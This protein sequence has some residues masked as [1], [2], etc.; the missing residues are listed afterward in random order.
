MP[1]SDINASLVRL[2]LTRLCCN[3]FLH[4]TNCTLQITATCYMVSGLPRA[5]STAMIVVLL[6]YYLGA[7]K[8]DALFADFSEIAPAFA[9]T[10]L[11]HHF[12]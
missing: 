11:H 2:T 9:V 6:Y 12:V 3:N 7:I 4:C 5:F 10:V 1:A 8:M